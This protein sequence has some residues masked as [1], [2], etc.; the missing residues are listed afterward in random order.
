MSDMYRFSAG[1][2][3]PIVLRSAKVALVVGLALNL[4]NQ[5]EALL[6]PPPL[7][8]GKALLTFCVPFFV[9]AYGALSALKD[10]QDR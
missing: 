6:G 3:R 1:S 9:S 7:D 8:W 10:R 4:I 2:W 5:H